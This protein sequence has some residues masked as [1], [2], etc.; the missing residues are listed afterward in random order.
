M[1]RRMLANIAIAVV[2]ATGTAAGVAFAGGI[3]GGSQAKPAS[4]TG[5]TGPCGIVAAARAALQEL[6]ADGTIT[7]AQADAVQAQV[8]AGSVDPKTLTDSGTVT[9]AQMHAIADRLSAVKRS[10]AG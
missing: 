2:V 3:G 5:A 7:Q 10:F 6:V 1:N 4:T 8:E 9:D